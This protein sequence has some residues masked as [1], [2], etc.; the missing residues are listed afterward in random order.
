MTVTPINLTEVLPPIPPLPAGVIPIVSPPDTLPTIVGFEITPNVP[1]Y[2]GT[3]NS[4]SSNPALPSGLNLNPSTGVISGVPLVAAA[5]ETYVI[6]ATGP[7]GSEPV[8]LTI[9]VAPADEDFV[10]D[11]PHSRDIVLNTSASGADVEGD[12]HGFPVMVRL[13]AAEAAIIGQAQD[14]GEDIRFTKPNNVTRLP[15]E[16][17]HWD[18]NGAVI[19][20]KVDTV[21]G[22]NSTQHIRM[23]WGNE[24]APDGSDGAQVFDTDNG[25]VAVWHMNDAGNESDATGHGLTAVAP[26][27]AEPGAGATGMIGP[28]R[29]FDGSSQHFVVAHD[30]ALNVNH[31]TLSAWVKSDSWAGSKR[32]MQ[33]GTGTNPPEYGMREDSGDR[34]AVNIEG[35][36]YAAPDN[37]VPALGTWG[38]LHGTFDGSN[39]RVYRDG[40][41]LATHSRTSS[42]PALANDLEIAK[43][44]GNSSSNIFDGILDEVRIQSVARGADWIRLEYE[45]QKHFQTLTDIGEQPPVIS[46]AQTSEVLTQNAAVT[47]TPSVNG[48]ADTWSVDPALP[49]GL[50]LDPVTGVISGAPLDVT[51]ATNFTITGSS[52]TGSSSHV[53]EIAV[54][55]GP[56]ADLSYSDNPVIY[57][58]GVEIDPNTATV[59]GQVDSFTVDPALPA[60]LSLNEATGEITGTPSELTA[61]ATY[62]VSAHNETGTAT[63]DLV[64]EVLVAPPA[65]PLL[66]SPADGATALPY[67]VVLLWNTVAPPVTHY[68]IEGS[69]DNFATTLGE[70]VDVGSDTTFSLG[71]DAV[72]YA[73]TLYWRVRGVNSSGPGEWSAVWSFTTIDAPP[74]ISYTTT[75]VV[76]TANLEITPNEPTIPEESGPITSWSIEP[77]LNDLTGLEFSTSTGV[78]SGT[79]DSSKADLPP[80]DFT[81]VA[82]GPGGTDTAIVNIATSSEPPPAISYAVTEV[83]YV[84]DV[85]IDP[86]PADAP[87]PP[88]LRARRK[89]AVLRPRR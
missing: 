28:G 29:S 13:G 66:V 43:Q 30:A 84:I 15:H 78:I 17:E 12:V 38:L 51:P 47:F 61:E 74:M 82:S 87:K 56:P 86:L 19:W 25:F 55:P 63:V 53:I 27:G 35:S 40:V 70:P 33:K 34:L 32:I 6:T 45:S 57:F 83:T 58:V 21:Y 1:S 42:V 69:E 75:P 62:V 52:V 44:P 76:Y 73:T 60:G 39:V 18:A 3:V 20:V 24:S 67:P 26:G 65:A 79:P 85:E 59:T 49:N 23:F 71:T 46:Y 68:E 5:T 89:Q 48:T 10:A 16:V 50:S 7:A 88:R 37:S 2:S 81:I 31:F 80:T 36:H 22:G 11:W 64:I 9:T 4:W 77:D 14:N 8:N 54:V 72:D 41:L